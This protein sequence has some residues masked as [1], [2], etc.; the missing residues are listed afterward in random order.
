MAGQS[1]KQKIERE[2]LARSAAEESEARARATSS[3]AQGY[4]PYAHPAM[5]ESLIPIW[6]SGREAVAD[7]HDGDY[8]GAGI[9]GALA[10]SDLSLAE[11]LAKGLAKGGFSVA[12]DA[13]GEAPY[14]WK[15]VV[16]PWMGEK[17]YLEAGQ[18][19][20]HWA[21][22]QNGWGK[23]VPDA[24]KNQPWNIKPMPSA[25]AHG[26]ITGSYKGKPRFNV[27][28]RYL[29]GT[30]TW[31]KVATGAALGHPIAAAK[32]RREDQ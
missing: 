9:N 6:G 14:G 17:G 15:R 2:R 29:H 5:L 18:H 8:V 7:F 1:L 10:V 13:A 26:R 22:P 11:S 32:G 31:S 27:L 23:T 21:I 3:T 19:G 28:E 4:D 20:H 24:I 12:K 30:P 25:E 16:R